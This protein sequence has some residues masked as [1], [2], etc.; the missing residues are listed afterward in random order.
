M[1]SAATD[2]S[3]SRVSGVGQ[4]MP[5]DTAPAAKGLI[6]MLTLAAFVNHLNLIAWN[7]FLPSI[8]EAQGVTV[9]LLGQVP[10]LMLLL[11]AFV[12]LVIGPLADRAG[13]RRALLVCVL[14]VA[15]SSLMT[16]LAVT[17][18]I[19]VLA[20]LVGAVGRA[21]IMPV[22][23]AVAATFFVDD[24]GRRRAISRIQ[25]GGPLAAT[26]GVPL[27]TTIAVAVQ[28][29]GAFIVLAGLAFAT[30]L[31][32]QRILRREG[33]AGSAEVRLISV[34]AAYRPVLRHRPTLTLIVAACV[35]NAGVNAMWTYYGAFYVQYYA[36][37]TEQVGWVSLAAGLGVLV[38]Q[39]AAGGCGS[40]PG[41]LFTVGC[42]GSGSLVGLSLM[43]SLPAP[44][45]MALMA[46]GW[47]MHG[48]VMVSTVVLLV[49][50]S[51]AGRATT[52]TLYGSAMSFGMALGA[53]LG[54]IA[55]A[56][57]GYFALGVCTVALPLVILV[58]IRR[59]EPAR[60][61]A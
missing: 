15:A 49:V 50:H 55:L 36:F 4:V 22:A 33:I 28:W 16:G 41:L 61:S 30:A 21:G 42:T 59:L 60:T 54:G 40:R 20:G 34:L 53:G 47:L 1:I 57:A 56:G 25:N 32:L 5:P 51:P 2:R 6:P 9:A 23:Q 43:L 18:P 24:T 52:L 14:A 12:G 10:A 39:T 44:A 3:A 29:R 37:S 58:S 45:A 11:S 38:G 13:Y 17:L 7:P 46:A 27:L 48:L 19:L 35:E 26:L 8:A 31:I